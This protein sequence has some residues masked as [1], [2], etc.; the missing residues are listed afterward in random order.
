MPVSKT[1][2]KQNTTTKIAFDFSELDPDRLRASGQYSALE[3]IRNALYTENAIHVLETAAEV[4]GRFE[5]LYS[6]EG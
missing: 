1:F 6:S 3:K 5:F 4:P 2:S